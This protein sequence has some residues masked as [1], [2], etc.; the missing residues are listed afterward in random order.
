VAVRDLVGPGAE[1]LRLRLLAGAAGL[2]RTIHLSRV[3]RP[4]L[5]LTGYTD[6]IRYGRVQIMG[7][8]EIG[9]LRKLSSRRRA[10]ILAQLARC[11]IS[12][13]VITKGLA[14]PAELVREAEANGTPL[15]DT[16]LESTP[17]IKL[18]GSLLDERLAMRLQLHS[19]LV[20]VFGLG[21]LIMGESGIGKSE[22]A[23]DLV[24]RGHRL[25]ADDVV[26]IKRMAE[27]LVGGAPDLTRYHMEI[28][29][30]GVL[31]IKDLYGVSSIR[32]SKRVDLV[33]TLERWE[34]GKEYDRLGLKNER[35][36]ILGVEVPLVRMPVAPGRNIALLVE[37]AARNQLLKERGYD[38]AQAFAESVDDMLE[39]EAEA[40][41][42]PRRLPR[43]AARRA[44][45]RKAGGR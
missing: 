16:P 4:G 45:R 23:L 12:C 19:V 13:F 33:V 38:A 24:D 21:V 25:V 32:I 1:A 28:R 22:C 37:V 20:D 11:R 41:S 26:E 40:R 17:F 14:P 43:P 30:L 8:S 35:F 7:A 27:A 36:L 18:L 3:Q 31:N 2:D 5:A 42:K 10:A 34:S 39:S 44:R 6:Y 29:G 15:L 9:Y